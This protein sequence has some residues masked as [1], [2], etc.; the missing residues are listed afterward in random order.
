MQPVLNTQSRDTFWLKDTPYSLKDMFGDAKIA[1][2]FNGGTVYQAFLSSMN[3][4]RWHA[5]VSGTIERIYNIPGTYFYGHSKISTNFDSSSAERSQAFISSVAARQVF[6]IKADNPK[7]GSIAL[8]FIGIFI[9]IKEWL[10]H[11]AV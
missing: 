2:H 9:I 10:K 1:A 3:Y 11:P 6:V 7:I 4:H 8:I 5:P